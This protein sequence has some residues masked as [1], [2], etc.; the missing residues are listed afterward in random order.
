MLGPVD[1]IQ[2]ATSW[3]LPGPELTTPGEVG[4]P[5]TLSP[6]LDNSP[7]RRK[8]GEGGGESTPK[9]NHGDCGL[10]GPNLPAGGRA[11]SGGQPEG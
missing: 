4:A 2:T 5:D 7:S 6:T 10:L 8:W 11:F 1:V 9:H 3:P